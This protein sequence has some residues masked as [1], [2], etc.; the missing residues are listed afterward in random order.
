MN[1]KLHL[2]ILLII[3]LA[4]MTSGCFSKSADPGVSM[5]REEVATGETFPI[6][7]NKTKLKFLVI[8]DPMIIDFKTNEFVKWYEEKTNIEIEWDVIPSDS[9]K[10][11]VNLI[12]NSGEL[13]DAFFGVRFNEEQYA[14][15][16]HMFLP[17]DDMIPK[18]APNFE[19]VLQKHDG[20]RGII[21]ATDGKIY[22]LPSWN[23]CYHCS[24]SQ[25]LWINK[26]WLDKLGLKEPKTTEEFYQVL[27]AFKEKDPNGNGKA[28]EIAFAGAA[29]GWNTDPN[30]FLMN[31]FTYTNSGDLKLIVKDDKVETIVNTPEYREGLRY[32]QRLYK[33]GLL[34]NPSYTQNND[35]LRQLA[36][37]PNAEIL[38]AF[39]TGANVNIIGEAAVGPERYRHY[40]ALAP[41]EGPKGVRYTTHSKYDAAVPGAFY[42]PTTSKNPEAALRWADYLYTFEGSITRSAG[43]KGI[44]WEDPK[45]GDVGLNGEPALGRR[46]IPYVEEPQN[47]S[48]MQTGINYAPE[49][50][51]F[52]EAVDPNVD[53]YAAEGL[54]KL[55]RDE[56]KNKYEPYA[57]KGDALSVL[58]PIKLKDE[59][60]QPIQTISV[61]LANYV[62]ESTVRFITGDLNLDK[63][64]DTYVQSLDK[65]GLRKYLETYQKGYDRQY[66]K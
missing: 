30:I 24:M 41:I 66:K 49:E 25:K 11:K 7:K 60:S 10:E 28:D 64:W 12:L 47:H 9:A 14:V 26:H 63:D 4:M 59:E 56:T 50:F 43:L 62:K 20:L 13:P 65:I 27:K 16:Q 5:E 8:Q 31:A 39:V 54:E 42:I 6:V 2:N 38:G 57:P 32:I 53:P 18:Y 33:E 61:E 23:D 21:T 36:A 22:G 17:L 46:L 58:P 15:A 3:V 35:Q 48:L 52:G 40:V 44:G 45:P 51:R 55:L 19:K 1:K 34:Y 29:N 37:S